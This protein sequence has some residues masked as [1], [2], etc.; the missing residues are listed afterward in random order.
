LENSKEARVFKVTL[1]LKQNGEWVDGPVKI[2]TAK[3]V[4]EFSK[5]HEYFKVENATDEDIKL[6]IP[7]AFREIFA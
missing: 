2:M 6:N 1:K 5:S 7:F 3:G 4:E